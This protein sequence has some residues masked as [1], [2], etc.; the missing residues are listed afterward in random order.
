MGLTTPNL[1]WSGLIICP[2]IVL[3]KSKNTKA[4]T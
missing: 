4:K 3:P 1:K 2:N